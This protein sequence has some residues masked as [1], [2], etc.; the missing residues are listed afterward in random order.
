LNLEEGRAELFYARITSRRAKQFAPGFP[1]AGDVVPRLGAEL[2]QAVLKVKSP[3]NLHC[4]R[5]KLDAGA[6]FAER[7]CLFK[8]ADL[9]SGSFGGDGSDQAAQAGA[10]DGDA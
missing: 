3:E 1:T 8:T 2:E 7:S 6:D 5:P 10:N 4:V 9:E